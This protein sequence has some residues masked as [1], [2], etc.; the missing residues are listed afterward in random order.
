L[1]DPNGRSIVPGVELVRPTADASPKPPGVQAGARATSGYTPGTLLA[2]IA[3]CGSLACKSPMKVAE[4]TCPPHAV[5]SGSDDNGVAVP[6]ETSFEDGACDYV[7]AGGSCYEWPPINFRI[8]DAPVHSGRYAA[9]ITVVTR[10]DGGSQPQGR[11]HVGPL[12]TE[13]YYGAWFFLPTRVT[14]GGLWNLIHFPGDSSPTRLWDVSL[15]SVDC[16]TGELCLQLVSGFLGGTNPVVNAV[17]IGRWFHV[18]LYLKRAKDKTG[19]VALYVGDDQGDQK[20]L[21][22]TNLVTEDS[23]LK[24]WYVGNLADNTTPPECTVYVDDVTLRSTL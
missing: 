12:P 4:F 23:D 24:D 11:C 7:R 6:W 9:E 21:E 10:T 17:P 8:V 13:A 18:V 2:A 5:D 3:L 16:K 22:Y 15:N 19:A 1:T 14:N 20:V